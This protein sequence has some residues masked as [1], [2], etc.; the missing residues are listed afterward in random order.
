MTTHR[1]LEGAAFWEGRSACARVTVTIRA[2]VPSPARATV[3]FDDAIDPALRDGLE[4]LRRRRGAFAARLADR[5]GE[6]EV[7]GRDGAAGCE[8]RVV[9]RLEGAVTRHAPRALAQTAFTMQVES[10]MGPGFGPARTDGH[11]REATPAEGRR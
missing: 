5:L 11:V 9:G 2:D 1:R 4:L 8:W 7:A 3:R 6:I 10:A